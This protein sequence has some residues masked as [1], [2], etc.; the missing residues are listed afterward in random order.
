MNVQQQIDLTM[1]KAIKTHNQGMIQCLSGA[2]F[3]RH[4]FGLRKQ[5]EKGIKGILFF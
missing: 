2:G 1:R 5:A 4:L 3:D